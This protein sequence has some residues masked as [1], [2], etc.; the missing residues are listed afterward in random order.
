MHTGT[1]ARV[2]ALLAVRYLL[3]SERSFTIAPG[4]VTMQHLEEAK[5][6]V[7]DIDYFLFTD[8]LNEAHDVLHQLLPAAGPWP[9]PI[10][11]GQHRHFGEQDFKMPITEEWFRQSNAP[12]LELY[13]YIVKVAQQRSEA[14]AARPAVTAATTTITQ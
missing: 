12:D 1:P 14:L 4:E 10:E 13:N 6:I 5:K 2:N 11:G 3:G 9:P 8:K 7:D